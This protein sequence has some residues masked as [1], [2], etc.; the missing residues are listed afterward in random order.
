[1]DNIAYASLTDVGIRRSHNQDAY[2]VLPAG[3]AGQ[4]DQRG[5][6]FL[7]A[8]GMGAHAVGELASKLAVDAIPHIYSKHAQEGPVNALRKAFI[9]TNLT[10]HARGQQNREFAGMGTTGTAL[11]LRPDGAWVGHVGDSR[12]YRV[13][14]GRI[15]QL[16]FD[17]SLV[18]ELARRQKVRPEELQG[19]PPNVIVR[20]LGPEPLVQVD[21]E[22]P[23][24]V[25]KGDLFVLCSD[26]LSGPVNDREIGAV[27]TALPP[28]EACR[29]LVDLANLQGGPDNITVLVVRVDYDSDPDGIQDGRAP[30]GWER[31]LPPPLGALVAGVVLALG[32]VVLTHFNLPGALPA[33]LLAALALVV[34]IVGLLLQAREERRQAALPKPPRPKAHRDGPCAIEMPLLH[35]LARAEAVLEG[36]L[37]EHNWDADWAVCRQ[38]HELAQR[39]LKEGDRAAAF[40]EYCRAMRPLTEAMHRQRNK[41]EIFQPVWDKAAD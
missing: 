7:V 29:F 24:E 16:S 19:I 3:D 40:R 21:V 33:F 22:G 28:E 35:K 20:S 8:D 4:W 39:F 10:I 32:A 18:W 30:Q 38:H 34:G 13:R 25:R 2:A 27:V 31:W 23:H 11:V 15:E 14:D 6:F 36:R 1:L 9:E 5:H 12:V 17:H 37:R 26:G 41:E